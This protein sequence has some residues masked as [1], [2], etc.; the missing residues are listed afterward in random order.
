MNSDI[1][2]DI[3][4]LF[5]DHPIIDRLESLDF[6]MGIL[7]KA[8][9]ESLLKNDKLSSLQSLRCVFNYMPNDMLK[10]LSK[11]FPN[12]DFNRSWADYEEAEEE[13][14]YYVQFVE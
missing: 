5:E 8:G 9:G 14:Y 7:K 11:K 1:Q 4:K 2:D 13:E 10:A 6:S 12:G 3:V